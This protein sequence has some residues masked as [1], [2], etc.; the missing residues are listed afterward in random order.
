VVECL[1]CKHEVLS[2]NSC[3][4]QKKKKKE[5]KKKDSTPSWLPGASK[6]PHTCNPSMQEPKRRK[7]YKFEASLSYIVRLCLKKPIT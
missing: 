1:L 4:A 5:K 2:S 3:P 7:D 6:L